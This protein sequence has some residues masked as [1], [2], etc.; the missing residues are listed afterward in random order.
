MKTLNKLIIGFAVA[1]LLSACNPQASVKETSKELDLTSHE[2]QLGYTIGSQM[3]RQL[4]ESDILHRIDVE[5]LVAAF[6]DTANGNEKRMTLEQM[7]QAD[8]DHE[9][10]LEAEEQ[11][12]AAANKVESA[13]YMVEHA[14]KEGVIKTESGLHYEILREG[15]GGTKPKLTDKI[16]IQYIGRTIDGV[17][18]DSTYERGK[19][20]EFVITSV[21]KG[22][23]EGLLQMTPGAIHRITVPPQLSYE[24]IFVPGLGAA[25]KIMIFE[26]EF[27]E[28]LES[29][30]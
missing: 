28:I 27:L 16:K 18:F 3:A 20:A 12:M 24:D 19:A 15:K 4:E 30:E 17:E 14:K 9:A 26:V 8:K 13:R 25:N 1:A 23:S 5:A 21:V 7:K 2:A 29:G 11:A 10:N 6:R 22:F